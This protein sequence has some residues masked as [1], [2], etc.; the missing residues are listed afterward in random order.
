[1]FHVGRRIRQIRE[2]LIQPNGGIGLS[3]YTAAERIGCSVDALEEQEGLSDLPLSTV[4]RSLNA[5]GLPINAPKPPAFAAALSSGFGGPMGRVMPLPMTLVADEREP[6]RI[7]VFNVPWCKQ[8]RIRASAW[9][10]RKPNGKMGA[11]AMVRDTDRTREEKR[12]VEMT[13][14]A[15]GLEL[16]DPYTLHLDAFPVDRKT[17]LDN[18]LKGTTDGIVRSKTICNDTML[19]LPEIGARLRGTVD[20]PFIRATVIEWR[21]KAPGRLEK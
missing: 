3:T 16:S 8:D 6:E 12:A 7:A 1:M 13:S 11:R 17:D 18:V 9:Q 21:G 10:F 5:W 15:L 4:L 20:V 19:R 2:S 14:R